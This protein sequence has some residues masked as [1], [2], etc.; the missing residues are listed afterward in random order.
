MIEDRILVWKFNRGSKDA[1][2]RI[3]EEH[4]NDLLG[5]AV[6]LLRDKSIAEDVVHDVF[7]SFAET[8]GTFNLSGTLKGYLST[9]VAN[10]ARDINRLKTGQNVETDFIEA[11]DT[12]SDGPPGNLIVCERAN[13]LPDLLARLPYEQREVIVLHLHQEMRFREIAGALGLS[14]NTVQ[15]RYRYGIK[16]LRTILDNEVTK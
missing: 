16:K 3:Y 8:V 15:S 9:C 2:R 14:I 7:V 13:F 10:R 1:F 5:L 11:T 12:T 4:K 6:S